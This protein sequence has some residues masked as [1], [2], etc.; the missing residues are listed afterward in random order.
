MSL[1]NRRDQWY[2]TLCLSCAA[3]ASDQD[4]IKELKRQLKLQLHQVDQMKE[5]LAFQEAIVTKVNMD[6]V[7]IEKDMEGLK[8]CTYAQIS[9]HH[10]LFVHCHFYAQYTPPTPTRLNC[11]VELRRCR[12]GV[13]GV[14]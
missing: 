10:V 7:N 14:Y 2:M 13:G 4:D 3:I 5:E 11:R 6:R 12:V 1:C 8:V 9:A